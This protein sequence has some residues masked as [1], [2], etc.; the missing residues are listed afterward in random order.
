M[1]WIVRLALAALALLTFR[2]WWPRVRGLR[3]AIPERRFR[4]SASG[5]GLLAVV[6]F[7]AIQWVPFGWQHTNPPATGEPTWDSDLTRELAVRCC[8]ACHGNQTT[9]PW[10]SH[11]APASWLATSDVLSG[12]GSLN[13]STWDQ[14]G[15]IREAPSAARVVENGSMP[16]LQFTL[17]HPDARLTAEEKVLLADGLRRSIGAR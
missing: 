7:V 16:P 6:G 9:W 10:Y 17:P 3:S 13:F 4:Q 11:V 5:L 1:E 14:A 12:R 8:Y 2:F 15:A